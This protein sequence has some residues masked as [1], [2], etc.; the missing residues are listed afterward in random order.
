MDPIGFGRLE[1]KL[2][3]ILAQ[4]LPAQRPRRKRDHFKMN[5][6]L[7]TKDFHKKHIILVSGGVKCFRFFFRQENSIASNN[8]NTSPPAA[9]YVNHDFHEHHSAPKASLAG[10]VC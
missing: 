5:F 9:G 7:P 3:K 6:H 4:T 8:N 10:R 1:P 2:S